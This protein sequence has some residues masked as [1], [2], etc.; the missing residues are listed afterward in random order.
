MAS[1]AWLWPLLAR[2]LFLGPPRGSGLQGLVPFC[3]LGWEPRLPVLLGAL[4]PAQLLVR[5]L[6][7]APW[8]GW[9]VRVRLPVGHLCPSRP[10]GSGF[11]SPDSV[12]DA[13]SGEC[14]A[15]LTLSSPASAGAARQR[16]LSVGRRWIRVL[17]GV[18]HRP[19]CQGAS[20]AGQQGS[21]FT[22]GTSIGVG[23][24]SSGGLRAGKFGFVQCKLGPC[25]RASARRG[26][27]SR[28]LRSCLEAAS[29]GCPGS[30]PLESPQG[31]EAWPVA[32]EMC[33]FGLRGSPG[34]MGRCP[35]LSSAIAGGF[36]P[37]A[38]HTQKMRAW[39]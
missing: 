17:F 8:A 1:P 24:G 32:P 38:R 3:V 22:S 39:Q 36:L 26:D 34:L 15:G 33:G 35:A 14:T 37:P 7:Q 20:T 19:G 23:S 6:P 11:L 9:G 30:E 27:R 5:C 12:S 21:E 31:S 10:W 2:G 25:G 16:I 13:T 18:T 4:F 29:W 28:R